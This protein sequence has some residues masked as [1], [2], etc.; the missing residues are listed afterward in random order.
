MK[1]IIILVVILFVA[2][3]CVA[4]KQDSTRITS[5]DAF[6]STTTDRH[7]TVTER[8]T[9]EAYEVCMVR[10]RGLLP[11]S[12]AP[13]SADLFAIE[14]KC[15]DRASGYGTSSFGG[16]GTPMVPVIGISPFSTGMNPNAYTP[17]IAPPNHEA[18]IAE[19]L[20]AVAKI[21][22]KNSKDPACRETEKKP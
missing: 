4:A 21:A 1:K 11:T 18:Q 8:N 5:P 12:V 2:N 20:H 17:V 19:T 22:C 3:A 9:E 14:Q 16:V 13:T 10:M 7:G 15:H 6:S